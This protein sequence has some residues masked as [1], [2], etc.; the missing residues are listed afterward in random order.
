M[1]RAELED[2]QVREQLGFEPSGDGEHLYLHI[3]KRNQNT[4]WVAKLLA[5][6]LGVEEISVGYCGL[7]DR[8]AVTS[9]WFSVHTANTPNQI[10]LGEGIEVLAI[11]R[12]HKKLRRGVH[13][14]NEFV[15]LLRQL[16]D[17]QEAEQRLHK[18]ADQGV[19]H[20]FGLQRFGFDGGNLL[21]ADK[22]L[23]S[24]S[25]V[26]GN[27]RGRG[28]GRG[29]GRKGQK[30]GGIY[31]SAARSYLFNLVLAERVVD[32]SWSKTLAEEEMPG[33]PLWGRGRSPAVTAVRELEDRVLSGWRDWRNG[34][35]FSGLQQQ[36]R[37][38]V[39]RPDNFCWRWLGDDLELSFSLPPGAYA[40]SV[41]REIAILDYHQ[42]KPVL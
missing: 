1:F 28:R 14:A 2:F 36:R 32:G 35:E 17:K 23:A 3:E 22:L 16:T 21:E 33:G 29:R 20:Y 26:S 4:R 34:L 24:R 7:K 31:L 40:T 19:P 27:R 41:L 42:T 39:L 10:D 5:E 18:I 12:H 30:R 38:L 6:V 9:Q 25:A 11:S 13:E 15:I 8:R 37:S